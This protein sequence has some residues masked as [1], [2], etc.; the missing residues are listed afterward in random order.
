MGRI[1][2]SNSILIVVAAAVVRVAVVAAAVVRVAIDHCC[3]DK[4]I[5]CSTMEGNDTCKANTSSAS[6]EA[7]VVD[8]DDEHWESEFGVS[9]ADVEEILDSRKAEAGTKAE[10]IALLSCIALKGKEL[11]KPGFLDKT[12]SNFLRGLEQD[13]MRGQRCFTLVFVFVNSGMG[14]FDDG[15]YRGQP[16]QCF[17]AATSEQSRPN[18]GA[19]DAKCI[20]PYCRVFDYVERLPE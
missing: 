5:G 15:W 19:D 20:R 7:I 14:R 8:G 16:R 6:A 13:A 3:D 12:D 1:Q 2:K 10:K 17:H 11:F 18:A 9:R 4:S